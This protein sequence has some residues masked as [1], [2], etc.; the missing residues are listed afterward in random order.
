MSLLSNFETFYFYEI[1]IY[2]HVFLNKL[3]VN[4]GF[5]L[6]IEVMYIR[7]SI[8]CFSKSSKDK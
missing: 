7:W 5:R 3:N 6:K 4:Y 2:F 8:F 1:N